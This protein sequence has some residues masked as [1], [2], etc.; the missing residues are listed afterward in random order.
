MNPKKIARAM[1][2]MILGL[3]DAGYDATTIGKFVLNARRSLGL[4]PE[5]QEKVKA[6]IDFALLAEEVKDDPSLDR[7]RSAPAAGQPHR[8]TKGSLPS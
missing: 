8:P 4:P 5:E 6:K 3:A 1:D 7:G 2:L